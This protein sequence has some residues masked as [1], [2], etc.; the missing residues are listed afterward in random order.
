MTTGNAGRAIGLAGVFA[1]LVAAL[2]VAAT[3]SRPA[4]AA[5]ASQDKAVAGNAGHPMPSDPIKLLG[6]VECQACHSEGK[7]EENP[8]YK[9][10]LGYQFVRLSENRVWGVHDLHSQAYE[11]LKSAKNATAKKMEERLQKVRGKAYTVTTDV[12]C[13]ACHA[14]VRLPINTDEPRKE[15]PSAQYPDKWDV[16]SF[17]LAEGVGC[18]M[19]HGHGNAYKTKHRDSEEVAGEPKEG[20]PG[21]VVPWREWSPKAKGDW[22]LVNLRDPSVLAHR[23][24]S[25][26]VGNKAEGR[27]VTHLM[28][29][30]GHPPLPPLDVLA[31]TREQ[32]RHWGLPRE[33]KYL[34]TLAEK[35]PKKAWD[36][37]HYRKE[38]EE[39]FVARRFAVTALATLRESAQLLAQLAGHAES[40]KDLLDYAAFDCYS[41]HHDLKYPS[42][43]QKRG[44][45]GYPGRPLFRPAAVAL[46]KTV[47]RH[48]GTMKRIDSPKHAENKLPGAEAELDTA[49][50]KLYEAFGK[51]SLGDP[52]L[53]KKAVKDLTGWVDVTLAQLE[54]V[55]YN[56]EAT[57]ALATALAAEGAGDIG[58]PE[59]AQLIAWGVETLRYELRDTSATKTEPAELTKQWEGVG[60]L[61]VTRLRPNLPFLPGEPPL[62]PDLNDKAAVEKAKT[63][64]PVSARI[65]ARLKLF[66]EFKSDDYGAAF[67]KIGPLLGKLK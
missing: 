61:V 66:N 12:D 7:P 17:A 45:A 36:T 55:R 29:A 37:F 38:S 46:A 53:I 13:L 28:Y 9:Q 8:L 54:D 49:T 32:P 14:T 35:E 64:V 31:Y 20:E 51:K 10:T 6:S 47:V 50:A 42:D 59:V 33:L 52:E 5:G 15:R 62:P 39:V 18:E 43:R 16:K 21:R 23:C 27:F 30:A 60:G 22:G 11:N 3:P 65:G 48:A 41:C 63:L 56:R 34:T 67:K 19:C 26:H 24:A 4:V 58:D 44:Y 1:G 25:C 57:V 2:A 40:E